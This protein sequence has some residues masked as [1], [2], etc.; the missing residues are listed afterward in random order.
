MIPI[1]HNGKQYGVVRGSDIQRDG[2]YL[3]LWSAESISVQ[4]YEVFYSDV[5]N[6]MQFASFTNADV[7]IEV[8]EEFLSQARFLLTSSELTPRSSTD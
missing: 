3:E 8:V 2:M 1:A 7:P 5:T 4:L 6:E